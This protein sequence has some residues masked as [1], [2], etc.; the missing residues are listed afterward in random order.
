M[1]ERDCD[2]AA[3]LRR[4][5]RGEGLKV[6]AVASGCPGVGK[7]SAVQNLAAALAE[8]GRQVLVVDENPDPSRGQGPVRQPRWDLADVVAGRAR[9]ESAVLRGT[10]GV[11]LLPAPRGMRALTAA[12]SARQHSLMNEFAKLRLPLDTV[13]VDTAVAQMETCDSL[14]LAA[15]DWLVVVN[16]SRAAITDGYALIKAINRTTA[17]RH[18]R[19]LVNCVDE[20]S[21][22]RGIFD[23]L[24]RVSRRYLA[25]TLEYFGSVPRDER[26][27][28]ARAAGRPVVLANPAAASAKRYRQLANQ[29]LGG[30]VVEAPEGAM[31]VLFE[32]LMHASRTA[33]AA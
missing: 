33:L 15:E 5:F 17:Q 22:A 19:I 25:V 16:G 10:H 8:A 18:F 24:A 11:A 6:I 13:L 26:L 14:S 32:R 23:N 31:A 7:S 1:A 3:G 21:S 20:E 30:G 28:K 2:Q 9:L 27:A 29:L 4:L 12:S